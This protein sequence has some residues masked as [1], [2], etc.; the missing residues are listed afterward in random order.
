MLANPDDWLIDISVSDGDDTALL[1]AVYAQRELP[2]G[3]VWS[4]P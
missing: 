3:Q 4:D 1:S 2:K